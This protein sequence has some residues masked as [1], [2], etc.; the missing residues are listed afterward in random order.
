V[1]SQTNKPCSNYRGNRPTGHKTWLYTRLHRSYSLAYGINRTRNQAVAK[2]ADHTA[3][4]QSNSRL[5][6]FVN[7]I[8]SCF[9]DIELTHWGHEFHL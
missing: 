1:T 2:I 7:S 8:S 5:F 4:Q 3:S 9:R 6:F